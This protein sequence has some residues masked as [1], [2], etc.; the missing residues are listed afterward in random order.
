MFESRFANL[1]LESLG[2]SRPE[3]GVQTI[4]GFAELE[5]TNSW[6]IANSLGIK[7]EQL[8][9]LVV[10]DSQTAGR[11]RMGRSWHADEGT[12]AL[13]ILDSAIRLGIG[14]SDIPKLALV[15]GLSVAEA[16]ESCIPPLAARIKWPNDVLVA[17]KKVAGV[18]IE[19]APHGT[20]TTQQF[21]TQQFTAQQ[22]SGKQLT[23]RDQRVVVG[24][25]V[26]VSTDFDAAE[27]EVRQRAGSLSE[28]AKRMLGRGDV[29]GE[30]LGRYRENV[31][32]FVELGLASIIDPVRER[33]YLGGRVV[34]LNR[35]GQVFTGRC[36]GI[37]EQG[38]LELETFQGRER[39]QSGEVVRIAEGE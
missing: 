1:K 17:G 6:A 38:E 33:C 39:F 7:D 15:A 13:S 10:C 37:T 16:I 21:T 36:L 18:L 31:R 11:G 30:F 25:G 19:N 34:R 14:P 4:L 9:L 12:L 22:Q 23:V 20:A 32:S 24:V 35:G 5:S 29:L 3:L 8:P 2:N 27:D 26:N 28:L